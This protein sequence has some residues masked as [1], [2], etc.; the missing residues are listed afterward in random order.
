MDKL[1]LSF[2]THIFF[3][4][5]K[6]RRNFINLRKRSESIFSVSLFLF[7]WFFFWFFFFILLFYPS[8]L[9]FSFTLLFYPSFLSFS[10]TLLFYPSLLFFSFIL[11]F[12]F[13]FFILP[14]LSFFF[15]SLFL[16]PLWLKVLNVR[17]SSKFKYW[18]LFLSSSTS[19]TFPKV[20]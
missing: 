11:P 18:P 5:I 20:R 10:F 17:L 19:K 15:S 12:L 3:Y 9:P 2:Y 8:F 1:G 6:F 16:A 4:F 13:F 7:L 14:F